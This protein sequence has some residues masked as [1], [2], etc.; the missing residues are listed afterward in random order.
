MSA[1]NKLWIVNLVALPLVTVVTNQNINCCDQPPAGLVLGTLF[2]NETFALF[3]QRTDG[4]GCDGKQGQ[5]QLAFMGIAPDWPPLITLNLD[6]DS[7][8]GIE[9]SKGMPFNPDPA[10]SLG[11]NLRKRDDGTYE[12]TLGGPTDSQQTAG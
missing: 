9:I 7:H 1:Q 2:F 12:L 6:F 5:F 10:G 3:Y 4:H 8:G 11:I